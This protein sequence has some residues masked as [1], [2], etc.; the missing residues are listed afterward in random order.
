MGIKPGPKPITKSTK[1][2]DQRYRDN[3]LTP[4]NNKSLKKHN[5]KKGD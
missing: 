5:H 4:G 2:Y 1:K 3:K